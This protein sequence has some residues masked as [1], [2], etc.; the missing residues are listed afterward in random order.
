[1]MAAEKFSRRQI[2]SGGC[3]GQQKLWSQLCSTLRGPFPALEMSYIKQCW[4]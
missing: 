3:L 4:R 2:T 1:M